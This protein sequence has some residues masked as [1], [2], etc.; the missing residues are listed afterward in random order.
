MSKRG[1]KLV[2]TL[3]IA[4]FIG[5]LAAY[6]SVFPIYRDWEGI[7]AEIVK[8]ELNLILLCTWVAL[9]VIL[10]TQFK[11]SKPLVYLGIIDF[12]NKLVYYIRINIF[13]YSEVAVT[14]IYS[15]SALTLLILLIYSIKKNGYKLIE[16]F[17]SIFLVSFVY[18][19]PIVRYSYLNYIYDNS[20][21]Y[22]R[23]IVAYLMN[24]KLGLL[25]F[26]FS[27]IVVYKVTSKHEKGLESIKKEVII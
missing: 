9:P 20:F 10:I 25:I 16:V 11:Y 17:I 24:P 22:T 3:V 7:F 27:L 23:N 8:F 5:N 15:V 6:T 2:I 19:I 21:Q 13:G 4:E 26:I 18:Y 12:V 14:I 1:I